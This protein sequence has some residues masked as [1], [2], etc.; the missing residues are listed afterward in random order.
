MTTSS[1]RTARL[2]F[3]PDFDKILT[4]FCKKHPGV[5]AAYGQFLMAKLKRP[6]EPLKRSMRDHK[7][8][9]PLNGFW[10]CHL[11]GDACLLYTDRGDVVTVIAIVDHD[12]MEGPKGRSIAAKFSHYR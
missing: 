10:E 11:A 8:S 2:A 4:K 5:A 1:S 7:L 12:D 9:G 3:D 6:P